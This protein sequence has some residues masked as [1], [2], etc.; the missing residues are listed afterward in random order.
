[1]PGAASGG[2]A[3]RTT[4]GGHSAF[5]RCA[6]FQPSN[7]GGAWLADRPFGGPDDQAAVTLGIDLRISKGAAMAA[8]DR[9]DGVRDHKKSLATKTLPTP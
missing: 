2:L 5:R 7:A 4:G 8:S 1:V 6:P 9:H 3:R